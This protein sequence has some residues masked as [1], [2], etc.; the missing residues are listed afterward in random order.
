MNLTPEQIEIVE[1][2]AGLYRIFDENYI[3]EFSTRLWNKHKIG[4]RVYFKNGQYWK[5]EK[6]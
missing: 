1:K 3:L 5:A 2:E 4:V 6:N